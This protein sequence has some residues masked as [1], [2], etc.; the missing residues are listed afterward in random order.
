MK[1]SSRSA[2]ASAPGLSQAR[3]GALLAIQL[4]LACLG[5]CASEPAPVRA[6]AP[7][8]DARALAADL[9]ALQLQSEPASDDVIASL[10]RT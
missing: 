7:S 6:A 9:D 1:I 10:E 2:L 8:N 4:A 3:V 5:G